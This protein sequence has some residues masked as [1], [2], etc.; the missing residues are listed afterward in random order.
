MDARSRQRKTGFSTNKKPRC[1]RHNQSANPAR[2]ATAP[3]AAT[4]HEPT[5]YMLEWVPVAAL[6]LALEEDA[7]AAALDALETPEEADDS[8][9]LVAETKC[10]D[11]LA[12]ALD[13][14]ET[15]LVTPVAPEAEP[16]RRTHQRGVTFPY[17]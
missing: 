9:A 5:K 10:D 7:A 12:A 17:E 14:L 6:K 15:A 1:I 16:L 3:A 2:T 4:A 13:A 11:R 8:A